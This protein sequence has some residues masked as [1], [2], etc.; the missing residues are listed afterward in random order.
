MPHFAER[1]AATSTI[2]ANYIIGGPTLPQIRPLDIGRQL[3]HTKR[4]VS[5]I[6]TSSI[7]PRGAIIF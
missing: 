2:L 5:T 7:H 4:I 6:T 1:I 3:E